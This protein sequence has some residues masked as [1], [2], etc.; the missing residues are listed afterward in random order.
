MTS[1]AKTP[2]RR[3][4][5][6]QF[7]KY[8]LVGVMNTLVTLIVI[9]VTK[10]FLGIKPMGAN[11]IGYAC[12]LVNSFIWNKT[13]VFRSDGGA[14]REAIRFALGFALCYALQFI[15]VWALTYRSALGG[16]Q[17]EILGLTFSGYAAA[18]LVGNI[19]YTVA[20]FIY[21]RTVTFR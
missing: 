18:T 13:W 10:S 6:L 8:A 17:W 21:N 1:N 12:G 7:V 5:L 3:A 9:Y 16:M 19:G 4:A 2:S 11:A 15:I 20:N 14:A